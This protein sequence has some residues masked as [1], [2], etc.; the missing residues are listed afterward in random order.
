MNP[1]L[2]RLSVYSAY[3]IA[4]IGVI[5]I[6]SILVDREVHSG[7]YL[8]VMAG[9][10]GLLCLALYSLEVPRYKSLAA[11]LIVLLTGPTAVCLIYEVFFYFRFDPK[12]VKVSFISI[13]VLLA[14]VWINWITA[15]KTPSGQSE[16]AVDA[17]EES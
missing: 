2:R 3:I 10:D 11:T 4:W 14:A 9:V 8:F 17:S 16:S 7:L 6:I 13:I 1:I 12:V 15:K 5:T